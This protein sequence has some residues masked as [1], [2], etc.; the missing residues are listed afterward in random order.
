MTKI[1]LSPPLAF[2]IILAVT[3][4]ASRLVS[5]I[6]FKSKTKADARGESYACGED[7]YD[8][9]AQPDYSNFFAFAFFFTIAHVAALIMTTVH[10]ENI[11]AFILAGLYITAAI[12]GLYILMR[13]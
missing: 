11:T 10:A 4:L 12:T 9:A 8:Q 3:L 5:I 13:D 1:L 2:I 7:N 6:S